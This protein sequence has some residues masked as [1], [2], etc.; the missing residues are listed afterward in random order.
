M[1]NGAIIP[2]DQ[3]DLVRRVT[4]TG[5]VSTDGR[6]YGED[7]HLARWASC[8]HVRCGCGALAEKPWT[9]CDACRLKNDIERYNKMPQREWDGSTILYSD[10]ADRYFHAYE[11]IVD[12]LRD[13]TDEDPVITVDDL[14][15]IVC[16]P[17]RPRYIDPDYFC[18]EMAED[19]DHLPKEIEEAMEAFNAVMAKQP[20]LS[21]SPGK[22]A[23]IVTID[24]KD[25]V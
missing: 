7:E 15:L 18:D 14:R 23:A 6:F 20:P 19:D 1:S 21:W 24:P 3:S 8:T 25:L 5:W 9:A 22:Y 11:E 17:N 16:E 10:A 12:Y 2:Y 4:A 13:R